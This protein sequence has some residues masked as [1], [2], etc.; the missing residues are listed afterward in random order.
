M[1]KDK[2]IWILNGVILALAILV[3]LCGV[4]SFRPGHSFPVQNPYGETVWLWGAG[5]YARD[6]YFKAP[7]FAGSDCTI[8]LFVLPWV[9]FTLWRMAKRPG[10]E[11]QIG[12]FSAICLLLYYAASAAFGITYNALHLAY[13]LLLGASFFCAVFL[14]AELYGV[15]CRNASVCRYRL[16]RGMQVYLALAGISLFV[17]WLPDI[18]LSLFSGRPLALID[19][20]TTEITNVLDMGLIS[21]LLFLTWALARR[22]TFMGYVLLRMVLRVC[23]GVGIM[24]PVQ[25]AFQLLAGISLPLPALVTKVLIFVALAAAS[26]GLERQLLRSVQWEKP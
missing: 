21:P 10:C 22:G 15:S 26:A 4:A 3:T 14:G 25:T 11:S 20:Y 17:A 19:V 13:I 18:L 16:S 6:S 7:I 24:L 5:V 9:A 2:A 8:L 12:N 23:M 1:R